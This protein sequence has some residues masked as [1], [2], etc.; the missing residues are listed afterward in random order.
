MT[1]I[2]PDQIVA[3]NVLFC[4]GYNQTVPAGATYYMAPGMYTGL[5]SSA[6]NILSPAVP[7]VFKSPTIRTNG[8]QP[9]GGRLEMILMVDNVATSILITIPLGA[10]GG[11]FSDNIHQVTIP[12]NSLFGWKL[13]NYAGAAVSAPIIAGSALLL[14]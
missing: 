3:V 5:F 2:Q 12:A 9:A 14:V 10:A 6:S 1:I 8:P 11:N 4:H 13:V 7:V